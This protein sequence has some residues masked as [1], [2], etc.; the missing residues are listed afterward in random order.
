MPFTVQQLIEGHQ[1][2]VTVSPKDTVKKALK[3]MIEHDFSQLP[4][5][6][7]DK[8]PLGII[9]SDS[10]IRALNNFGIPLPE[11]QVSHTLV[12]V[13]QYSPDE[14][15]FDLLDDLKRCHPDCCGTMSG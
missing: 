15:L 1:E 7:E 9:T 5:V 6:D 10:I 12:K 8:K 13:D 11:L 2:P 4:V 14:D 3:L